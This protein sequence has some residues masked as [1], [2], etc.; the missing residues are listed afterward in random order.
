MAM[1]CVHFN[2]LGNILPLQRSA[3]AG[4]CNL[5][6]LG[7]AVRFGVRPGNLH[8]YFA[9][10]LGFLYTGHEATSH[11]HLFR[12]GLSCVLWEC[13]ISACFFRY[14]LHPSFVHGYPRQGMPPC[15]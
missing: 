11:P 15:A 2:F 1:A 5:L 3:K 4:R 9:E 12:D 8:D 10:A 7:M 6:C 13:P 14:V